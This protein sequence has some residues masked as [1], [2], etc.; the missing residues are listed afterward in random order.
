MQKIKFK[1]AYL[2]S[3]LFDLAF[4]LVP[5]FS[6]PTLVAVTVLFGLLAC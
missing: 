1:I 5:L 6:H 3:R 2:V 4:W